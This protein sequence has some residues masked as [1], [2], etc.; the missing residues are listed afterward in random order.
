MWV[1]KANYGIGYKLSNGMY[2]EML[3]NKSTSEKTLL[4]QRACERHVYQLN[5][6]SGN[7]ET[8]EG[9]EFPQFLYK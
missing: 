5:K 7:I 3:P 9:P 4:V 6:A 1:G 2:G 8:Y